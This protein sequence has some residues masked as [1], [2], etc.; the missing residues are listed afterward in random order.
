M[1]RLRSEIPG[2]RFG[3][4][5][6]THVLKEPESWFSMSF[7]N[8]TSSLVAADYSAAAILNMTESKSHPFDRKLWA[9]NNIK[10]EVYSSGFEQKF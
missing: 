8:D 9:R 3:V 6:S 2:S 4:R 5:F 10:L 1:M 7:P